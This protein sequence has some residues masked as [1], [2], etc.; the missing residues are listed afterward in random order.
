MFNSLFCEEIPPHVQT[1]PSF[2][3]LEPLS[4]CPVT[5]GLGK[6][7]DP[8][9][10]TTATVHC[11][12]GPQRNLSVDKDLELIYLTASAMQDLPTAISVLQHLHQFSQ[13]LFYFLTRKL[14]PGIEA[15]LPPKF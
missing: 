12:C 5:G 14:V 4:S 6:E 13:E 9:L 15:P 11:L 3:Q 1:E 10:A 7:T 2:L 8:H